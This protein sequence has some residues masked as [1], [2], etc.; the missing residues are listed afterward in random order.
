MIARW[1]GLVVWLGLVLVSCGPAPEGPPPQPPPPGPKRTADQVRRGLLDAMIQPSSCYLNNLDYAVRDPDFLDQVLYEILGGRTVEQVAADPAEF[2]RLV[3]RAPTAYEMQLQTEDGLSRLTRVIAERFAHPR[4]TVTGEL[5]SADYGHIAG[6]M[7]MGRRRQITIFFGESPHVDGNWEWR[8]PEV[9]TA[10]SNLLTAY[11]D[12]PEV[13]VRV[14]I[15][16][17]LR[18][19]NF[20]YSYSR[21][22]DRINVGLHHPKG[23]L[24]KPALCYTP[25][26]G[27]DFG[28]YLRGEKSLDV[29]N[30][31]QAH[32]LD[33]SAYLRRH[34]EKRP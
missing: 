5:V 1:V 31:T 18:E 4:V 24:M 22:E 9:A 27:H 15:P 7:A 33:A 20:I 28:P 30:L 6:H 14:F 34:P 11:P 16:G 26:L 8:T 12:N 29:E 2:D 3:S 19:D 23:R 17:S 10:L 32:P 25:A 13:E 21:R